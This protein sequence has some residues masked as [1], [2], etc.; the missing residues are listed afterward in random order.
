MKKCNVDLDQCLVV[1]FSTGERT[2]KLTELCFKKLGFNNIIMFESQDGLRDKFF[3]FAKMANETNYK[4]YI[5]NDAD[6]Y[7]FDGMYELLDLVDR[8]CVDSSAGVGFDFLMNRYR[9]ATPNVFSR[10]ALVYLHNNKQ[11]MPDVQKPLTA[12]GRFLQE[13]KEFVDKDYSVLTNLHDYDQYPSKVC[14]TILNRIFRG[15]WHLYDKQHL[16]GLSG[17]YK[18]AIEHAFKM[19]KELKKKDTIDYIQFDFLDEEYPEC[20]P[21]TYE[22]MYEQHKAL[23]N[24]YKEE[25][26]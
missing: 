11:I 8:N 14:N 21:G 7:V 4:Y 12:F 6:R 17:E 5:Q 19:A 13:S 1:T 2:A 25:Y 20:E 18:R 9:G 22:A 15:H 16:K 24:N 10:R 23:Y 26:K 3:K